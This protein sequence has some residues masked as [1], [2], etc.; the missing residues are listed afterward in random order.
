VHDWNG[1]ASRHWINVTECVATHVDAYGAI[2]Q[3]VTAH[4]VTRACDC[5]FAV[6]RSGL[7]DKILQ[8][9]DRNLGIVIWS[10]CQNRFCMYQPTKV[11]L[12]GQWFG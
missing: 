3:S 9:L 1:I 8:L 6:P 7:V 2:E 11:T 5:D 4:G 12:S 10:N